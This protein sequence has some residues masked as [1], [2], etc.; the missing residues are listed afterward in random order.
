MEQI[1]QSWTYY[2]RFMDSKWRRNITFLTLVSLLM[3]TSCKN[4]VDDDQIFS[5]NTSNTLS[6]DTINIGETF[7]VKL[8][9]SRFLN[10][11]NHDETVDFLD[12]NW[13]LSFLGHRIDTLVNNELDT[14]FDTAIS[15]NL[16]K[17]TNLFLESIEGKHLSAEFDTTSQ[18]YTISFDLS[19]NEPGAY[20]FYWA[21]GL[22]FEFD[23][24]VL[25]QLNCHQFI[26]VNF[27]LN[28]GAMNHYLLEEISDESDFKPKII[29]DKIKDG[30]FAI[31]VK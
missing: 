15:L 29:F 23:E 12:F 19:I 30:T 18:S 28:E 10:S 25:P 13:R 31:V 1:L 24:D 17:G 3:A 9:Y 20:I 6:T 11:P 2:L 16:I 14:Q 5:L 8:D 27:D 21:T 26:T 7:E 22:E 4:C